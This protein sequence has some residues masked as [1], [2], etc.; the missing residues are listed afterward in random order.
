MPCGLEPSA[1]PRDE[2]GKE[3]ELFGTTNLSQAASKV[4]SS[5]LQHPNK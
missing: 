4:Q 5:D 2:I 1:S 3:T